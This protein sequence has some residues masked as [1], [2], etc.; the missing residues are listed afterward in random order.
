MSALEI[1]ATIRDRMLVKDCHW[2]IWT[3]N[4]LLRIS[5][6]YFRVL[7]VF[8][9]TITYIGRHGKSNCASI[10]AIQ[11]KSS[12]SRFRMHMSYT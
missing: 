2:L 5:L 10:L 4:H 12:K 8:L 3:T 1:A 6:C 7:R 11:D 9:N